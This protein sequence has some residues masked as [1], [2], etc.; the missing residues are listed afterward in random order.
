MPL[1]FTILFQIVMIHIKPVKDHLP[2]EVPGTIRHL[3]VKETEV[4]HITKDHLHFTDIESPDNQ[5]MYT[6]IKPC[7]TSTSPVYV[8]FIHQL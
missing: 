8:V 6:I 5:L 3:V 2:E 7:F 1:D 4:A